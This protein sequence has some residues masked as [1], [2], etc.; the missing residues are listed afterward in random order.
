MMVCIINASKSELELAAKITTG[1]SGIAVGVG[2]F[3]NALFADKVL[4]SPSKASRACPSQQ[5]K[6]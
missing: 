3:T 1:L 6:D 5:R 2:M 4:K